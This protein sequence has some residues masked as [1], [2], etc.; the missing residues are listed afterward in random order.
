MDRLSYFTY[1]TAFGKVTLAATDKA[2]CG[3]SFGR[4]AYEG[5]FAPSAL[6][7][8]AATQLQEYLAGKR[9]IFEVPLELL[10][11]AFQESVWRELMR[12]PY[13]QTQSY[14][15]LAAALGNPGAGRAVGQALNANPIPIFV[16]CHRVISSNGGMGG[17]RGGLKTKA[18]LLE[19]EQRH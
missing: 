15:Q 18:F 19:L 17:Y 14:G 6:T 5:E 11:T 12:I 4:F 16:P 2:L 7:N 13:G 9:R 1:R 10:G 3:L 8:E